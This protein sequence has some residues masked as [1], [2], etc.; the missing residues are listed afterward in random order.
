M[1]TMSLIKKILFCVLVKHY[2]NTRENKELGNN[3]KSNK[4]LCSNAP[5]LCE[6]YLVQKMLP[7]FYLNC[8]NCL[9]NKKHFKYL[10]QGPGVQ[11]IFR[12]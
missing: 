12:Y 7:N 2:F 11:T 9:L 4:N 10:V 5:K 8:I 6:T 1:K 3:L